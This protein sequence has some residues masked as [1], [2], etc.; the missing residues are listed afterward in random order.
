MSKIFTTFA[1]MKLEK[2]ILLEILMIAVATGL[3]I[4]L[5]RDYLMSLGIIILLVIVEHMV[6]SFMERK[7]EERE[8]ADDGATA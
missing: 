1:R 6:V 4:W 8:E 7:Q 3:L 2:T 5:T